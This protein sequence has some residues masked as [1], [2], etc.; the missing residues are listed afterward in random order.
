MTRVLL[1]QLRTRGVNATEGSASLAET[2]TLVGCD[3]AMPACLLQIASI[4]EASTMLTAVV[5]SRTATS[6]V[7]VELVLA[8]A[9]AVPVRRTATLRRGDPV[10]LAREFAQAVQELLDTEPAV[11]KP[12]APTSASTP[13]PEGLAAAP[14][15][16]AA[17]PAAP[18]PETIHRTETPAGSAPGNVELYSFVVA[19]GGAALL[20]TGGVL[21]GMAQ[22]IRDEVATAPTATEEDLLALAAK[23]RRGKNLTRAGTGLLSAG[24]AALAAGVGLILYQSLVPPDPAAT[25]ALRVA[26]VLGDRRAGV[27]VTW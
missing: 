16:P 8:T 12:A 7:T 4:L 1:Q 3:P 6:G 19:G 9:G 27:I 26:P 5:G 11:D 21:L 2:A 23:E 14:S 18:P 24:G 22:S 25:T 20:V 15:P 10:A 17:P 13:A